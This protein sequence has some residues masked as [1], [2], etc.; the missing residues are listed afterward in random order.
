M[1]KLLL[2]I[3]M[4]ALLV[5]SCSQKSS[6][7]S[8]ET[9]TKK[10]DSLSLI[11]QTVKSEMQLIDND[12]ALLDTTR[13]FASVTVVDVVQD[14]FSHSFKV[15]GTVKSDQSIKIYPE[16]AGKI[17]GIYVRGGDKVKSGR[18]L[19]SLDAEVFRATMEEVSTQLNL[20]ETMFEKQ[21]RLW[22]QKV[23][24]EMD[25]LQSKMQFESLENRLETIKKQLNMT[26]VRAPFSGVIDKIYGKVGEYGAP[27]MPLLRLVGNGPLSVEMQ[28]PENYI[29]SIKKGQKVNMNFT[30]IKMKKEGWISQVGDYIDPSSRTFNVSVNLPQNNGNKVIKDNM[31]ASVEV[32]DYHVNDAIMIPNKLILQDTKGVNYTYLYL[33]ENKE[34][35][36]V[37]RRDL[38]LGRSNDNMTEILSGLANTDKI[39]NRG[40]RSVQSGENVK[41]Y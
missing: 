39:I 33:Y 25:F 23:G 18:L 6:Q 17:E 13:S 41:I 7:N 3:I 22:E 36:T 26:E 11:M 35:G 16:T 8:I 40:I 21:S 29:T 30:A 37:M 2:P 19:A 14:I 38:T 34:I 31:M 28:I 12:L 24:S 32:S 27:G 15:Y 4:T 10:R 1:N 9:L 20:A 5:A